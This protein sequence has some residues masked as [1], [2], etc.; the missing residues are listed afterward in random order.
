MH[1]NLNRPKWELYDIALDM[2]ETH[3]L[4]TKLP[5]KVV[6]LERIWRRMNSEMME[7]RFR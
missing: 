6:E 3:D 7:P 2:G 5:E 4:A 1:G